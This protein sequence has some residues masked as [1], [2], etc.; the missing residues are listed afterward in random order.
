MPPSTILG[1]G[2]GEWSR[3][4]RLIAVGLTVYESMLCSGCGGPVSE[5]DEPVD[6]EIQEHVCPRCEA[7][8]KHAAE[9]DKGIP[10]GVKVAAV[11]H[12]VDFDEED[13][14]PHLRPTK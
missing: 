7:R 13:L 1:S 5:W 12:P 3:K 9:Y 6:V 8:D 10:P 11:S 2:Q 14:P 4:D